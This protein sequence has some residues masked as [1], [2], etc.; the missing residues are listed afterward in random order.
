MRLIFLKI[1]NFN[2][3]HVKKIHTADT[4]ELLNERYFAHHTYEQKQNP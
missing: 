3:L 2:F 1:D 4:E